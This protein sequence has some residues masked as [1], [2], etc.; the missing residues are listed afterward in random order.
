MSRETRDQEGGG[1]LRLVGRLL[2]Y[3]R[4]YPRLLGLSL[5]LYPL[6]ALC[7]IVPPKVL[8]RIL[9]EAIPQRDMSLLG[10][11]SAGYL[12]ALMLEYATG[13][14]SELTTSVLGQRA[15]LRLRR[16]LFSHVQRLPASFFDRNPIGRILTR[17]TSDVEALSDAFSNG[18]ITVIA[19]LLTVVAVVSMM[20]WIDVRLTLFSF[21]VA[22][23]LV[24]L[25]A[26]FQRY[27][28]IAFRDIRKHIA[29]LN[30]FLAEHIGGM[31]VVQV[32]GQ[33][34]RTQQEF[35]QLNADYR[36]AN[37]DAIFFD[38]TLY[39][40][41]EAIGTTAV[42]VLI[43]YG[44]ADLATGAASAGVLMAFIQYIRR[45]FIPIRD[46]STKYTV[47][48]SAFAAAERTFKLLDEPLPI[49]EPPNATPMSRL[50]GDIVFEGAWFAYRNA[51]TETPEWVL[52]GIDFRVRRGERVALVGSTGSGKTTLLKLLNR[53]YD[54]QRGRVLVGGHD[55]RHIKLADLRRLFAVVL[56][57]V[58]LFSGTVMQNLAFSDRVTEG[59]ARKAVAMVQAEPLIAR[60]PG[61][62]DA[63]VQELGANFS[64]G[65]RQLLALARALAIN[66]EVLILDE[67][68]SNVDSETE[69]RIQSALDVLLA[70]RT[71]LV[72]AHRLSTIQKVDRIIVMQHGRIVQEGSHDVL[73]RQ[74]GLYRTLV[75]LQFANHGGAAP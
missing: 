52:K 46:L 16:D 54:V 37:R 21:L 39:A 45:F 58:H 30:T 41:V 67:A 28:R 36:D 55:V 56:Q 3:L 66:P 13:F 29:R 64:A 27:A 23:P 75:E 10:W 63:P 51:D 11:L 48:Q 33:Q 22:P 35:N 62:Y 47:L 70:D 68:T 5:L 50:T 65:E 12:V 42:A 1:D 24:G 15:M 69:A 34:E 73:M 38:A 4:A 57:D 20:L 31:S 26:V 14:A 53:S 25:A 59:D 32:F 6:N 74:P 8:Q 40:V 9:D 44:A 60:L 43:W 18:A 49:A 2:A 19:D 7:V 71:A 17:L 61:G 72:V